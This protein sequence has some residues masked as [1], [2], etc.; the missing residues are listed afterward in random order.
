MAVDLNLDRCRPQATR[1]RHPFACRDQLRAMR[2]E[3]GARRDRLP[4]ACFLPH[5]GIEPSRFDCEVT[6]LGRGAGRATDDTA[7][8]NDRASDS[9]PEG[10][11]ELRCAHPFAALKRTSPQPAT[12]WRRCRRR[13]QMRSESALIGA[14]MT[15]REV[16]PEPQHAVAVDEACDPD[17]DRRY[18]DRGATS[19]CRD[20]LG[21]RVEDVGE[22]SGPKPG[23]SSMIKPDPSVII[24]EDLLCLLCRA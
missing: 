18:S 19:Q 10:H 16:R 14:L 9:R 13:R 12:S 11:E 3:R 20:H 24:T 21:R 4:S 8:E 22:A 2:P 1:S 17:T 23:S 7:A 15:L 5:A 6:D